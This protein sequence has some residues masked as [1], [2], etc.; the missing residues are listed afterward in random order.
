MPNG[1][2][3]FASL[4]L[5]NVDPPSRKVTVPVAT[6]CETVAVRV[7]TWAIADGFIDEVRVTVFGVL[8]IAVV[9]T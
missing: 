3:G 8:P 1:S 7:T 6:D 4:G 5:I 2:S 9:T